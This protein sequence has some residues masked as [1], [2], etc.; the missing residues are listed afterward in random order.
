MSDIPEKILLEIEKCG[1]VSSHGLAKILSTD[2]QKI[3]GA[4][5]SLQ[6][7]ED[8][9]TAEME[10]VKRWELTKEGEIVAEKGKTELI[11]KCKRTR[12]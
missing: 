1:K 8:M 6:C 2:H 5:K 12:K 11:N 9:I 10:S 4:I 3:V 7:L